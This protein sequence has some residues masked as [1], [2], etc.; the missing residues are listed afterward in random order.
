MSIAEV[1]G[2][3]RS[4]PAVYERA[5]RRQM[6]QFKTRD[7]AVTYM[8]PGQPQ[9]YRAGAARIMD[10]AHG[11]E[12]PVAVPAYRYARG[13][14]ARAAAEHVAEGLEAPSD[15]AYHQML[16]ALRAVLAEDS[17]FPTMS[18]DEEGGIIAE[19]RIADYSLEVDVA[20]DGRFSYTVRQ[21]GKRVG[22]GR[23]QTPLRKM[24]RDVSAVVAHVN[25]NW[26]SLFPHASAPIAR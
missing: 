3:T 11:P 16:H 1:E 26:R 22:G 13:Q 10:H 23:S 14:L 9:M 21:Q 19:W 18:I 5:R 8:A 17:V 2:S 12:W 4:L 6:K 24:I 7:A 20:P 25:P 15:V